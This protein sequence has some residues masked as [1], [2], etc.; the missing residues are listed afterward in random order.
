MTNWEQDFNKEFSFGFECHNCFE[1]DGEEIKDFIR[2]LLK[3]QRQ[4]IVEVLEGLKKKK[5]L[6][7]NPYDPAINMGYNK[8]LSD[9]IKKIR[10]E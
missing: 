5:P 9:A 1:R 10:H 4:E 2:N 3:Q 8:A 7:Y 6:S